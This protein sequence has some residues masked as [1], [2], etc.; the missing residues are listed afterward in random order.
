MYLEAVKIIAVFVVVGLIAGCVL[1]N[2]VMLLPCLMAAWAVWQVAA[3]LDGK[4]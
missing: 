3:G 4:N 1:G 2:F